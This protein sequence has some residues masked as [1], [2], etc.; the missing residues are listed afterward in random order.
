MAELM[1][2]ASNA[3]NLEKRS[4]ALPP[5]LWQACEEFAAANGEKLSEVYRRV[6]TLGVSAERERRT[7]DLSYENKYLVNERLKAKRGGAVEAIR[8]LEVS[9]N[10]ATSIGELQAAIAALRLWLSE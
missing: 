1:P 9:L 10:E 8:K 6:V 7:A 2:P 5:A 3:D 4:V